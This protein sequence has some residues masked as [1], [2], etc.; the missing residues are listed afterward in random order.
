[1]FVL[2]VR[3]KPYKASWCTGKFLRDMREKKLEVHFGPLCLLHFFAF[4]QLFGCVLSQLKKRMKLLSPG[5][6][7]LF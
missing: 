4:T 3:C 6:C 2:Q 1:M 5:L 7:A